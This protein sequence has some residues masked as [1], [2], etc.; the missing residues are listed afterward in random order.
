[1]FL[2]LSIYEMIKTRKYLC[3]LYIYGFLLL[4]KYIY[5]EMFYCT[6]IYQG[7]IKNVLSFFGVVFV[8]ANI[9]DCKRNWVL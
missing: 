1:M 5:L 3:T 8:L 2:L 7:I 4:V 9:V 6:R